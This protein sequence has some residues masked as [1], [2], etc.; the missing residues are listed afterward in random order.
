MN[1]KQFLI[2]FF[3]C[4][5]P[6]G[7]YLLKDGLIG[8]DSYAFVNF[9]CFGD[10]VELQPLSGIIFPLLPCN[11]LIFKLILFFSLLI[12]TLSISLLGELFN[13]KYGWLSGIFSFYS[14]LWIAEFFKFED[15][16]LAYP[17]LLLATYFFFK[18]RVENKFKYQAVS[19]G[20]V[21]LGGLIW[22]GALVYLFGFGFSSII[23]AI[24]S[25]VLLPFVINSFFGS[26][27]F[28]FDVLENFPIVGLIYSSVLLL[29]FKGIKRIFL[30][31]TVW[32]SFLALLNAKFALH[33]IPY[34]SV[35]FMLVYSKL[36]ERKQP[37]LIALLVFMLLFGSIVLFKT[38]PTQQQ[39]DAIKFG[40]Q[41]SL[42][43][44]KNFRHDW[45]MGYWIK[46]LRIDTNYFGSPTH[47]FYP[48]PC[49]VVTYED[50]NFQRC[51]VIEGFGSFKVFDCE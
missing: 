16:Q 33:I 46:F 13:K 45:S 11:F 28:R 32:F 1:R 5:I 35:G 39:W 37:A 4:L 25:I 23:F 26:I 27:I 14:W 24:F 12:G 34:L 38:S 7:F 9:V 44:N 17:L 10:F 19:L 22:K 41:K 29:G 2:I 3:F 51:E 20:L 18:G 36:P 31:Q 40:Y 49:I 15:D 47:D 42:D 43:L 6:F 48:P 8:A 21:L 50:L 30:V